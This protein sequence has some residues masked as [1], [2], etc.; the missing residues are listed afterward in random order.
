MASYVYEIEECDRDEFIIERD[1]IEA[2]TDPDIL[3]DWVRGLEDKHDVLTMQIDTF[4]ENPR[5]NTESLLWLNR[6][7]MA[8]A[9]TNIGLS[10]LRQRRIKLGLIANP[11]ERQIST[12]EAKLLTAKAEIAALKE[13]A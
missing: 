12:L 5:E 11:M 13:R 1:D 3:A 10:R 9:A 2:E 6:V 7:C 4:R 8:K